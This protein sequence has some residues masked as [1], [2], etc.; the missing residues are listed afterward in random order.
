[1]ATTSIVRLNDNDIERLAAALEE[2][3]EL[4]LT[5]IAARL[6]TIE[7]LLP[8]IETRLAEKRAG[9]KK[10]AVERGDDR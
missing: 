8:D 3:V 4:Q 5:E 1:M 6:R 2:G 7:A 10:A 9:R